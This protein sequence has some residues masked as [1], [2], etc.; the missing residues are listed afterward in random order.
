M[1]NNT[2]THANLLTWLN[3][4]VDVIYVHHND[5][6]HSLWAPADGISIEDAVVQFC[7]TH[8]IDIEQE[9]AE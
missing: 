6:M 9:T 1:K 5:E 2:V 3:G 7:D 8:N 4:R